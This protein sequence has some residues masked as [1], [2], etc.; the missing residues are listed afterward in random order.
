M[1]FR[2][3][4]TLDLEVH[5]I[6]RNGGNSLNNAQ[7]LCQNCHKKTLSYGTPGISPPEFSEET[8]KKALQQAENRCQCI[9][10]NCH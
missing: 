8:K 6:N 3:I 10:N 4:Q 7:V 2:C 1:N 9:R 5:H